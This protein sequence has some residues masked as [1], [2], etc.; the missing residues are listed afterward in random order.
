MEHC[1]LPFVFLLPHSLKQQGGSPALRVKNLVEFHPTGRNNVKIHVIRRLCRPETYFSP[2]K[3]EFFARS[4]KS[5]RAVEVHS[6]SQKAQL[7]EN[8]SRGS[9]GSP[10]LCVFSLVSQTRVLLGGE[11][12]LRNLNLSGA[13]E[14]SGIAHDVGVLIYQ[15]YIAQLNAGVY[16]GVVGAV[17]LRLG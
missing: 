2:R 11:I 10:C 17:P 16:V 13:H 15:E 3:C 5:L 9:R 14:V 4:A 12:L 8:L 6:P 1:Y 7:F